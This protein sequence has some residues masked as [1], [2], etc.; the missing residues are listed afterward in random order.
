MNKPIIMTCLLLTFFATAAAAAGNPL[1]DEA[2][3]YREH[4]ERIEKSVDTT[5][6]QDLVQEGASLADKLRPVIENLTA[7]D[8]DAVVI[9]MKGFLVNREEV[10]VIEP[11]AAFFAGLAKKHGTENDNLYFQFFREVRPE[12]Y[13]PVYIM[14]QTDVGGCTRYGEGRLANLFKK[15]EALLPKMT[16][17]YAKETTKIL[18]DITYQLTNWTCACGDKQSVVKELKLFL[19]LNKGSEITGMVKRR[20]EAVQNQT[21]TMRYQCIGGQ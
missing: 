19:Q 20:L 5:S 21:S 9:N 11:D 12:G 4:V 13:W 8:Y 10:I 2:R 7:L 3:T 16:G 1:L 14:L 17:Y 18:D 6:I 15:G